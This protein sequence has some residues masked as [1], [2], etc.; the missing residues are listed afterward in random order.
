MAILVIAEHDNKQLKTGT[1]NTIAAATKLGADVTVLVAGHQCAEAAR[2]RGKVPGVTKVLVADAAHYAVPTR[3]KHVGTGG[4]DRRQVHSHPRARDRLR[5]EFHAARGRAAR[6]RADLRHQWHRIG[7]HFRAADL[8][9]QRAVDGAVERQDQGHHGAH[10][11]V[12]PGNWGRRRR[13]GRKRRS[14]RRQRAHAVQGPGSH[15]VG[16]AGTDRGARHR[17]G[18]PRHGQRREF[19]DPRSARRQARRGRRRLARSG[20]LGLRAPTITRSGRPAR[21]SRPSSTSRSAFP[22]R[23]SIWPA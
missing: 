21:S 15:Q 6:R 19:Q 16:A 12:R 18:R 20:R 8:R 2:R 11:R 4:L 13:A 23:S 7:R 17:L 3:R 1:T 5:Q 14:G 22:A 9:R 10:H